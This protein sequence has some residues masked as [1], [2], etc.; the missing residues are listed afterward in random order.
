MVHVVEVRGNPESEKV[1][2]VEVRIVECIHIGAQSF[3]QGTRQITF[4][5]DRRDCVKMRLQRLDTFGFNAGFVHVRVVEVGDFAGFV[6]GR[7]ALAHLGDQVRN[8]LVGF[9][10]QRHTGKGSSAISGDL[11]VLHPLSTS[12]FVKVVA[13]PHRAVHVRRVNGWALGQRGGQRRIVFSR[14]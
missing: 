12:I 2:S 1:R 7:C 3:A 13:R 6:A 8:P 14:G 4:V 10:H 5:A 11:G 9:I